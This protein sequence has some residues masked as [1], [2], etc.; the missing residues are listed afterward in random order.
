LNLPKDEIK[1]IIRT[2]RPKLAN[3]GLYLAFGGILLGSTG[4]L[5]NSVKQISTLNSGKLPGS[6]N[7]TFLIAG[8]AVAAAGLAI[9]IFGGKPKVIYEAKEAPAS[10]NQ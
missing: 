10:T 2:A 6:D 1:N 8:V 3:P 4:E 5:V 7:E 9:L